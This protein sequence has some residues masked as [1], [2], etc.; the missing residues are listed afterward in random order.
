MRIATW[1]V[2]RLKHIRSLPE[3]VAVC[4]SLQS[5]ILV[6]TESDERIMPGFRYCF[7]TP[8]PPPLKIRGYDMPV[9]Y[10]RTEH[11]VSI[12]TNYPCI[13]QHTTFDCHT[14]ICL[15]LETERGNLLVYGTIMGVAGNRDPSF[16]SDLICQTEDFCKFSAEHHLCICGDFNC[17]FADNYYYT[18]TGRRQLNASFLENDIALLTAKCP[19]CID[20]IA[21]SRSFVGDNSVRICEWN[22]DKRLSDHK[23]VFVEI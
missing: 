8:T 15:E 10:S 2:E 14:A 21:V 5:D 20:H 3:I 22:N 18:E 16:I 4:D 6:L 1:N 7:H 12:Y 11:R 17:S 19:S 13:R 9:M 23:G